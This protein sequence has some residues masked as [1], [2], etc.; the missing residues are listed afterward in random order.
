MPM[1][2]KIE[3]HLSRTG[4]SYNLIKHPETHNSIATARAAHI[5]SV[6]MAK[7]VMTHDHENYCLCVIPSNH[8]LILSWLNQHMKGHYSLVPE[9]DLGTV[10]DD[11]QPG[12]IPVLG[13]VYGLHVIWDKSL[14]QM[15]D[16]YFESGDH[17][18]LIHIDQGSFMQLMGLQESAAISCPSD[19]LEEVAYLIH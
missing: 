16:I 5:P 12:A 2:P 3:A 7:A 4:V 19:D 9:E 6:Q 14:K 13:Q 11:C 10:F 8:R 15:K 17:R 18:N 1:A